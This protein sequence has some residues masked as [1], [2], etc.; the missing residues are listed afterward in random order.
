MSAFIFFCDIRLKSDGLSFQALNNGHNNI[1][2]LDLKPQW[3]GVYGF[4]TA[5]WTAALWAF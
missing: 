3:N 4:N 5:E 2:D 1:Q